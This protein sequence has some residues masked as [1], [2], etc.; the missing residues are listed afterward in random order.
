MAST[1]FLMSH[2]KQ[3]A[4][5]MMWYRQL[6]VFV[7]FCHENV[8][9]WRI[10]KFRVAACAMLQ[11]VSCSFKDFPSINHLFCES[12]SRDM[13][14]SFAQIFFCGLVKVEETHRQGRKNEWWCLFSSLFWPKEY[15]VKPN[16]PKKTILFLPKSWMWK[17]TVVWKMSL[18][19]KMVVSAR[20][21]LPQFFG[22]L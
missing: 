6:L 4:G 21:R 3:K 2:H 1:T 12:L 20:P 17:K 13:S 22:A 16:I 14:T 8:G 19:C 5:K 10:N 9:K 7:F 18:V 15:H 11:L